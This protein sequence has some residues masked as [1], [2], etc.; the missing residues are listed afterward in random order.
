MSAEVRPVKMYREWTFE[1]SRPGIMDPCAG[2]SRLML[3]RKSVTMISEL[4]ASPSHV[5][6]TVIME[7]TSAGFEAD[8]AAAEKYLRSVFAGSAGVRTGVQ[9]GDSVTIPVTS[10][11]PMKAT[12]ITTQ[13]QADALGVGNVFRSSHT[14]ARIYALTSKASSPSERQ[15]DCSP[16]QRCPCCRE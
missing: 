7:E 5:Q 11:A 3:D 15:C 9:V 1:V 12:C 4:R 13:E 8:A 2:V 14:T 16:S 6:I 10:N